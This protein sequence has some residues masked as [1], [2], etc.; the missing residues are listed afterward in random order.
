MIK[1]FKNREIL[2][3]AEGAA[4]LVLEEW[5][6]AQRRGATILAELCGYAST[7]DAHHLTQPDA[8]ARRAP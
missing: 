5:D 2:I 6:S 8:K 4:M 1:L 3:P 7:T